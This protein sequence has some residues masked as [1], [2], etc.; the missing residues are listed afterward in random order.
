MKYSWKNSTHFVNLD[1]SLSDTTEGSSKVVLK[2]IWHLE[3]A[4]V[5]NLLNF[6]SSF[7]K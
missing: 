6:S 7:T 3:I 2:K 5:V 4:S 1:I